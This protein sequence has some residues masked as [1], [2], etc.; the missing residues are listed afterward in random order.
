MKA[1]PLPTAEKGKISKLFVTFDFYKTMLISDSERQK[2]ESEAEIL[3]K[4]TTNC[5][6]LKVFEGLKTTLDFD[7]FYV[8]R[9]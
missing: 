4:W 5:N 2:R 6:R 8:G 1:S 7:Q 3:S 9:Y